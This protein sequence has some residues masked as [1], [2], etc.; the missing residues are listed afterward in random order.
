MKR[1]RYSQVVRLWIANP[2]SPS[3]NLGA[4]FIKYNFGDVVE[5]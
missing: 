1:R 5:W 3:S 2:S 4:A